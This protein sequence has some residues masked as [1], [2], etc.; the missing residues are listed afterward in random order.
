[1]ETPIQ[2]RSL[3]K[4]ALELFGSFYSTSRDADELLERLQLTGKTE[5]LFGHLSG[6]EKQR[7]VLALALLNEPQL[8]FLDE[9]T[10]GRPSIE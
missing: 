9:P 8:L 6:G 4:E 10:S 7:L 2:V 3:A 1:M 5:A